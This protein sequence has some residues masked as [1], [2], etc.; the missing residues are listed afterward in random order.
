MLKIE[1][2]SGVLPL[3]PFCFLDQSKTAMAY[4]VSA[5]PEPGRD[6][7]AS[8]EGC[9]VGSKGAQRPKPGTAC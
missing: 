5:V 3:S 4:N 8:G 1:W 9:Q 6:V 2:V 7:G